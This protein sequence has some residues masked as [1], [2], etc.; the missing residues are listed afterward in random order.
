MELNGFEQ[1]G[2]RP[3]IQLRATLKIK[4]GVFFQQA[5]T[6]ILFTSMKFY[7]LWRG[8]ILI[9]LVDIFQWSV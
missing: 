5:W 7:H 2:I 3:K 6:D 9:T 1:Q 4:G 8:N